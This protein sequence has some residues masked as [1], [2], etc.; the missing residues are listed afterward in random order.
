ME[1]KKLLFCGIGSCLAL[2]PANADPTIK[3][4][5]ADKPNVLF[6]IM[7][8]MCD[9][10]KFLGGNNQALTPNLDRLAARGMVFTNAYTAVPLSNPSRTAL[11]TGIQPFVTG[12]YNNTNEISSFPVANNSLFMPRHFHDNG[13][14]TVISGKI[15]HTKPS[16][17]VMKG[18]WDDMTNID[19]G[20]GPFV[21]HQS[22]PQELQEKWRNYEMWT[23]PDTD[24]PDVRN[25][26]KIINYLNQNHSKPFFAAMGF[27]RPHNPYTAPKRYFDKYNVDTIKLP[28]TLPDDLNDIPAYAI[29]HF[30][31]DRA[32]TAL[33]NST[34]NC[35][36][37]LVRAYLACVSFTDD[38][39]GMILDALDKSAYADN[40]F[41]VLIGD[42][43]FHH[44]EKERWGK[45]ALWREACHVPFVIVPPK[46][47]NSFQPGV[48]SR[49][50]NLIDIYPTLVDLCNL[51]PVENQLAGT[52]LM[53]LLQNPE[54]E[55]NKPSIST[56]LPGNFVVHLNQWNY[57]K[58][59]NNSNEL[60]NTETD[61]NEY[62]NL[63]NKPEYKYMVDS[64]A[65][66]LP[67]EWVTEPEQ[68]KAES[69]SE[70]IS[71]PEWEAE[72]L[73]L[74]PSFVKPAVGS[75]FGN[76][77]N[78]DYY[79]DKYLLKGGIV[80]TTGTPNCVME[81]VSHGNS[82]S[83]LAF[84]LSN[85]ST[86][87][88]EFPP[89]YNAG[90]LTLHVRSG[91]ANQAGYIAL[92]Q[93]DDED[94]TT[95]AYLD[96]KKQTDFSANSIGEIIVYPININEEVK[97]RIQGGNRFT[98]IFRVD[99]T[100]YGSVLGLKNMQPNTFYVHDRSLTVNASCRV[101]LYN[102]LGIKVFDRYVE[103][104]ILFP[105]SI[106]NGVF[107]LKTDRGVRKIL[108]K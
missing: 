85:D 73:R 105:E 88:F 1:T 46:S 31:K 59:A 55:W 15:F 26:Q 20:Y 57:I 52:D 4:A 90:E 93:F 106:G 62:V 82:E 94:W 91:A 28:E 39:I 65:K 87:F 24:F 23:G 9:W 86:G 8:D 49:T 54:V 67:T 29:N 89:L 22:L 21:Q 76:I 95:L 43:G 13:Y 71:T 40:T 37:Q 48:C 51:P 78:I 64:L 11:L 60:Y 5:V 2:T 80:N 61:E 53:S 84:R 33:L 70:D 19:G 14:E 77:N 83:A 18:M 56:F 35:A 27:Y 63:A 10:A 100:P 41:I 32:K 6:I 79:F 12:V 25:S 81:G 99:I 107:F 45:S 72:I 103:H 102:A 3:Q 38:R 42:N 44:G 97:L 50:V 36:Q 47:M 104:A 66:F 17:D 34:G 101:S 108:L 69:V 7:D 58:Y 68:E 75:A 30:I 92:Q 96:T 98:Q 16:A 74:N